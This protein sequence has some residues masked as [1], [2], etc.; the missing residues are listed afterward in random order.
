MYISFDY[1]GA[2][3]K[4]GLAKQGDNKIVVLISDDYLE[5]QF[6]SALP[7]YIHGK[8]VDFNILNRCHSDLYAINSTISK[9]ITEQC[10]EL[11]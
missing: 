4:A 5:K 11:L 3:Y 2:T 6:G 7:F 8:S 1:H 9:A 10:K